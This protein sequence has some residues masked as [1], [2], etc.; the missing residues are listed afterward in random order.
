[1]IQPTW[2]K[3]KDLDKPLPVN[4]W[5][6]VISVEE[7]HDPEESDFLEEFLYDTNTPEGN[8]RQKVQQKMLPEHDK[9]SHPNFGPVISYHRF[10]RDSEESGDPC[11][12]LYDSY[13]EDPD[14]EVCYIK[15][16]KLTKGFFEMA[17]SSDEGMRTLNFEM[18][19]KENK[20]P[21]YLC[22]N[23]ELILEDETTTTD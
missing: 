17:L 12:E 16:V 19:K 21:N 23:G 11:I 15:E 7:T 18:M 4:S 10:I 22:V 13:I 6:Y 14:R 1:M 3:I 8:F 5:I 20:I 9:L 2:T